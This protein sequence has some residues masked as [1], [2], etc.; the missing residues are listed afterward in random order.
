MARTKADTYMAD[1]LEKLQNGYTSPTQ[2]ASQ[3][4]ELQLVIG[5]IDA[6]TTAINTKAPWNLPQF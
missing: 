3:D 2:R 5:K 4:A 1:W 6:L